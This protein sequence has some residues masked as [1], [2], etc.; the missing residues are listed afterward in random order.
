MPNNLTK[1]E[2]TKQAQKL[3]QELQ[4]ISRE[5]KELTMRMQGLAKSIP[6]N[7]NPFAN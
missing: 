4:R 3:Q 7:N 2:L 6:A 5:A 1:D